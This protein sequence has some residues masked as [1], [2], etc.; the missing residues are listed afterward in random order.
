M[1]GSSELI[2]IFMR[3]ILISRLSESLLLHSLYGTKEI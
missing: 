3:I 1:F 2:L